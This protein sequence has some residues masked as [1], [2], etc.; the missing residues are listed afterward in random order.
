METP[1]LLVELPS[2]PEEMRTGGFGYGKFS[3]SGGGHSG[4]VGRLNKTLCGLRDSPQLWQHFPIR[5]LAMRRG[6]WKCNT[7]PR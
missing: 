2:L 4:K 7:G 5:F 6:A 3:D 1:D